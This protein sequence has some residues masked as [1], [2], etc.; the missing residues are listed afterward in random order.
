MTKSVRGGARP[1]LPCGVDLR[2]W[3]HASSGDGGFAALLARRVA[4]QLEKRKREAAILEVTM[5]H[6][7][8]PA[9]LA[10]PVAQVTT[11]S[12][13]PEVEQRVSLVDWTQS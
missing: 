2:A 3:D 8:L 9:D 12:P 4:R 5:H 13:R 1:Y 7:G 11:D 10:T 6:G